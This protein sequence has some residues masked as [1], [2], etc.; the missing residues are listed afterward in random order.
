MSLWPIAQ[1]RDNLP[2]ASL[3]SQRHIFRGGGCRRGKEPASSRESRLSRI[4]SRL[5]S[6]RSLAP[7][8]VVSPCER[9]D[10]TER[11][12]VTQ[13]A[14]VAYVRASLFVIEEVAPAFVDRARRR[15]S[16]VDCV[17]ARHVGTSE[18]VVVGSAPILSVPCV[19]HE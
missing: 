7:S 5:S 1:R 18:T 2:R 16:S 8:I 14:V 15:R 10:R 17:S 13:S 3:I 9:S 11:N 19:P 12:Y 4:S 6:A